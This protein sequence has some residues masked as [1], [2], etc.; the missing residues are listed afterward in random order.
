VIADVGERAELQPGEILVTTVTN[1]GWTPLFPRVAAVVTDVG[2]PL[3]HAAIVARELGIPAVGGCDNATT[4]IHTGDLLRVEGERGTVEVI[5]RRSTPPVTGAAL[6]GVQFAAA[7]R[8]PK[9]VGWRCGRDRVSGRMAALTG[10][11]KASLLN[12]SIGRNSTTRSRRRG[13]PR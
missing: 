1:V 5:A 3:S 10:R 4:R 8:R 7:G 6:G 11:S 12:F 2:A 9:D 13:R